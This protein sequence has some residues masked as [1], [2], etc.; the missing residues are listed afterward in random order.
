MQGTMGLQWVQGGKK[1]GKWASCSGRDRC[2]E[3]TDSRTTEGA[4]EVVS[5]QSHWVY[6]ERRKGRDLVWG[7][8]AKAG[9]RLARRGDLSLNTS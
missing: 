9:A 6:P 2:R 5:G 7:A 8:E 3:R 4:G 1:E